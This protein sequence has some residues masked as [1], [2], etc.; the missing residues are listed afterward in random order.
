MKHRKCNS[1]PQGE[2]SRMC[3]KNLELI[4]QKDSHVVQIIIG[5][6]VFRLFADLKDEKKNKFGLAVEVS[7]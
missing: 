6:K 2:H 4:M 5:P 7:I 3:T 1:V